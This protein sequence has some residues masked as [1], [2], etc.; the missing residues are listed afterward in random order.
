MRQCGLHAHCG[1][2]CVVWSDCIL[3]WRIPANRMDALV[4]LASARQ[5]PLV[6]FSTGLGYHDNPTG[7][8]QMSHEQHLGHLCLSMLLMVAMP[9]VVLEGPLRG[10]IIDDFEVEPFDLETASHGW[11]GSASAFLRQ[12]GLPTDHVLFGERE[13]SLYISTGSSTPVSGRTTFVLDVDTPNLLDDAGLFTVDPSTSAGYMSIEYTDAPAPISL[14]FPGAEGIRV[15]L[16]EAPLEGTLSITLEDVYDRHQTRSLPIA[17]AGIYDFAFGAFWTLDLNQIHSLGVWIDTAETDATSGL[18]YSVS[19]IRTYPESAGVP[20]PST[21]IL[22]LSA[23]LG[24]ALLAI[25]DRRGGRRK[26]CF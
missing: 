21:M 14:L 9:L 4:A 12:P 10:E 5:T 16:T 13:I 8:Q 6:R 22:V 15:A 7:N 23:L 20:E 24:L 25:S 1:R 18:V 17:G 3:R 11:P 26:R 19:D 2:A